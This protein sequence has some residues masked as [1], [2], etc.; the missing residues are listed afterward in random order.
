MSFFT[1]FVNSVKGLTGAEKKEVGSTVHYKS[2]PQSTT[3]HHPEF[4]FQ[5]APSGRE[6]RTVEVPKEA[7][8]PD[9]P[10]DSSHA[11]GSTL[12]PLYLS[13]YLFSAWRECVSKAC[14]LAVT[15]ATLLT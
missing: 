9:V 11:T 7:V 1:T 10:F 8:V 14:S 12:S 5:A 3:L 13:L 15:S 6:D 2:N 4:F